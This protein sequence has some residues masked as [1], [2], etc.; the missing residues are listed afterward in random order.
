MEIKKKK[1]ER[2]KERKKRKKVDSVRARF[3][4]EL[5][6][7]VVAHAFNPALGSQRQEDL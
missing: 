3:K 4:I 7:G 5:G 1:K 2:K 6:L